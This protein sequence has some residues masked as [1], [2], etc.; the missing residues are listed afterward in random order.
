MFA[1]DN[2]YDTST[3]YV[4]YQIDEC[5]L[6]SRSWRREADTYFR[7]SEPWKQCMEK[8]N[9]YGKKARELAEASF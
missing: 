2:D 5:E 8:A 6:A 3:E 7:G 4:Q 1:P 9:Y